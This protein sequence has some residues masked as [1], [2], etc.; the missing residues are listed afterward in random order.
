M[1]IFI[2]ILAILFLILALS[3]FK[4]PPFAAFIGVSILAGVAFGL[5]S[6]DLF[7]AIQEGISSTMGS[8]AAILAFGSI[9]GKWIGL[10][11]AAQKVTHSLV[12]FSGPKYAR[13]AFMVAGFLV[14]L[15]LFYSVAFMLLA[16]LVITASNRL[17][18][19]ATFLAIPMLASLTVTQGYLPPHPAPLAIMQ[20]FGAD[21]G[22]TLF[23]GIIIAI[24]AI[25]LSGLLFGLSTKNILTVPNQAFVYTEDSHEKNPLS[26]GLSYLLILMPILLLSFGSFFAFIS[27]IM[28]SY[29]ANPVYSLFLSVVF[30]WLVLKLKGFHSDELLSSGTVAIKDVAGIMLIFAGAGALK[31]ILVIGGVSQF[32]ANSLNESSMN[33]YLLGWSMAAII[34]VCVGSSTVAGI[35]AAGFMKVLLVN[36]HADP[37]LLVL[38]LGAGSMMF[39]HVNDT[40]FWLFREYFQLGLKDTLKSWSTMD[41]LVSITGLIGV[42]VLEFFIS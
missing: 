12:N 17:K 25:L 30:T 2:T 14:G 19:P 39:S 4:I 8:I 7:K 40:G 24:P 34:R 22:T 42:L 6:V 13:I 21:F 33:I 16:P 38:A 10:S 26:V 15:P 20:E 28:A 18:Q 35:T 3:Y 23:Y 5:S 31:Q 32:I 29:L 9:L 27:P 11:G 41:T 1:L 36:S 37:N